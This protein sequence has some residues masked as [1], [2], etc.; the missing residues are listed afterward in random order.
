MMKITFEVVHNNEF[1]HAYA[2]DFM[3]NFPKH[4]L[5]SIDHEVIDVLKKRGNY[6]FSHIRSTI[7]EYCQDDKDTVV[8][9]VHHF[10]FEF[11]KALCLVE[12]LRQQMSVKI[13][14]KDNVIFRS[15]DAL[16]EVRVYLL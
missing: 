2:C 6:V 10:I 12:P 5:D 3:C 4:Q 7:F 8:D 9:I 16:Q 11:K 15:D 1:G 14:T 13:F